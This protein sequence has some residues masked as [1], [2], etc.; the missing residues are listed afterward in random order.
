[1]GDEEAAKLSQ[2]MVD[3]GAGAKKSLFGSKRRRG[4]E[5]FIPHSLW[6]QCF[7]DMVIFTMLDDLLEGHSQKDYRNMEATLIVAIKLMSKVFLQLLQDLA[8]DAHI[9][10][11]RFFD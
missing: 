4:Q 1:M 3:I 7:F 6:L 10:A 11:V 2:D 5:P 9:R 8:E